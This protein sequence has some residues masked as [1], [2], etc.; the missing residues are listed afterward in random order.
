MPDFN[1]G[2]G[3]F[4]RL[5]NPREEEA[6]RFPFAFRERGQHAIQRGYAARVQCAEQMP[7]FVRDG[8]H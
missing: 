3:S 5:N 4:V 1:G 7:S 8:Q 2:I 6:E